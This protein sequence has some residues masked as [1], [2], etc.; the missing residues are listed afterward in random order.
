M[1]PTNGD[2]MWFLIILGGLGALIATL[3]ALTGIRQRR[4]G[5]YS[6]RLD[7]RDVPGRSNS[8][9]QAAVGAAHHGRSTGSGSL[10]I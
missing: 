1:K 6:D 2:L 5:D 7:P 3:G 8:D 9:A 4:A 10:S